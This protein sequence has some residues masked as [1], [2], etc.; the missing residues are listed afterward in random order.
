MRRKA[1]K[2]QIRPKISTMPRQQTEAAAYLDIYKLVIEKKR[3]QQELTDIDQRRQQI[4][5]RLTVLNQQVTTLE[6]S[7][8]QLQ[9]STTIE[10]KVRPSTPS[11]SHPPEKPLPPQSF[12][13]LMLDY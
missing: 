10:P 8:H 1:N 5:D 7:A 12:D 6:Q 2:G 9:N 11:P 4:C 3:L 13:T